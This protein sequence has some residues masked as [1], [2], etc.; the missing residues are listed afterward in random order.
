MV[1]NQTTTETS[2]GSF[3]ENLKIGRRKEHKR[4][5]RTVLNPETGEKMKEYIAFQ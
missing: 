5:T 4:R 2:V 3:L 1:T